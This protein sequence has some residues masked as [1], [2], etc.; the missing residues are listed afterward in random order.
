MDHHLRLAHARSED[1]A[2]IA[3][4]LVEQLGAPSPSLVIFFA[5]SRLPFEALA[6]EI[7]TAFGDSPTVGCTTCGEIGPEGCSVGRVSAIAFS[8]PIRAATVAIPSATAFRFSEG[9]DLLDRL[10]T[11]LD[12]TSAS[13]A[14][15]PAD[16]VMLSLSD[17]L[18]GGEETL[19]TALSHSAPGVALVGGSSADDF[20]F[21]ATAVARDGEVYWGGSLAILMEP[22]CTFHAFHLHHFV[23]GEQ[24]IVITAAEPHERLVTRIDGHPAVP[25]LARTLSLD[26]TQLREHPGEVLNLRPVVFGTRSGSATFMRSVMSVQGD[27]LL[28]GGAIEEGAIVYL[29]QSSDIVD[30]TRS[31]LEAALSLVEDPA[32]ALLFNCGGRMWEASTLGKAEELAAAMSPLPAVGFTTYGEQ[33]GTM[34][35][36]HTLTGLIFGPRHG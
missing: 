16:F 12:E 34:Q 23:R 17:G 1:P 7:Q 6:Q 33:F 2:S 20:E 24:A 31:G 8:D 27:A 32:A 4:E 29:M 10:L 9:A 36:N 30:A 13:L 35:I 19:L 15:R 22:R 14:Q 11:S 28:M 21:K 18:S 26:E 25:W 5:S 3:R